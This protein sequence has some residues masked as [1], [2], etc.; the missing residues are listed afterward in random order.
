MHRS[1]SRGFTRFPLLSVALASAGGLLLVARAMAGLVYGG[2]PAKT[3]CYSAF[4]VKGGTVSGTKVSC[5]AG[6]PT[7]DKGGV[8]A[9]DET[10][11]SFQ[12]RLCP[13]PDPASS[14]CT[15][16]T[17]I[18]GI[19]VKGSDPFA[20]SITFP[21][22]S[23]ACGAFVTI[24]VSTK[25][26]GKKTVKGK[27]AISLKAFSDGKPKS[28]PDKLVLVCEPPASSC[29]PTSCA[30]GGQA[31]TKIEFTTLTGS[32]S[33]GTTPLTRHC[34]FFQDLDPANLA[35]NGR[36]CTTESDCCSGIGTTCDGALTYCVGPDGVTEQG[37][38]APFQGELRRA[39]DSKL[40]DLSRNCLYLGGGHNL[41]NKPSPNPDGSVLRLSAG[42]DG[43]VCTLMPN[44]GT[45]STASELAKT[46][47]KGPAQNK[48]CI[49]GNAGTDTHGACAIDADCGG[50]AGSCTQTANCFFGPPLPIPSPAA[51]TCV[52][53][54]INADASG[55]VDPATGVITVTI[56][57]QSRIYL[58]GNQT[59]PCPK[60][61]SNTCDGGQNVG[62]ACA[63]TG[64]FQTSTDCPPSLNQL[65]GSIPVTLRDLSTSSTTKQDAG[66]IFCTDQLDEGAFGEPLARK[67]VSTGSAGGDLS[68]F[69]KHELIVSGAFC[70]PSTGSFLDD[71]VGFPGPGQTSLRY[72]AQLLP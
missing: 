70:V 64:S 61:V 68:D 52:V 40:V 4:D 22:T 44:D 12:V 37:P 31:F 36:P 8:C 42:L 41:N 6:D 26:K 54:A 46:C 60:C 21:T 38:Q 24:D 47:T 53:N 27:K 14:K 5:N 51:T 25:K 45:G 29:T 62:Q 1:R 19:K 34:N 33:C 28:D 65:T 71:Y 67:I 55:T 16:P 63:P 69:Q 7:C 32:T 39:D 57:L 15:K 59:Q 2:G 13:K 56:P 23:S 58:T 72:D 18:T 10:T 20:G 43:G 17:T 50:Q 9:T 49:N 66:G 30:A 3:D 48:T 11:C 35:Q